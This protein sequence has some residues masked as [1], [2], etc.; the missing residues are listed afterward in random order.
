MKVFRIIFELFVGNNKYD[1]A[2]YVFEERVG[3]SRA[4]RA[5]TPCSLM[6]L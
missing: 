6:G 1:P 4:A 5:Q 2:K 3:C